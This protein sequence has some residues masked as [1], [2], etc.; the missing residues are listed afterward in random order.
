MLGIFKEPASGTRSNRLARNRVL[1]LAQ[2]R[3]I[4]AALDAGAD[5]AGSGDAPDAARNRAR[6]SCPGF[7]RTRAYKRQLLAAGQHG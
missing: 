2:A 3:M 5:P 4:D 7:G 6:S 1:E